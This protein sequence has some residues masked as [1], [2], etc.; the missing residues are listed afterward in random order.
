MYGTI[1]FS[2]SLDAMTCH[3]YHCLS[4]IIYVAPDITNKLQFWISSVIS[5]ASNSTDRILATSPQLT[6]CPLQCSV[7]SGMKLV[8]TKL[9][10]LIGFTHKALSWSFR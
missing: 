6:K 8:D 5:L 2:D 9:I 7:L 4:G 1:P 10:I 3:H